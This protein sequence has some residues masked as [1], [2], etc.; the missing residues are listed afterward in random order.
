[1]EKLIRNKETILHFEKD[2]IFTPS[3]KDLIRANNIQ[4]VDK[5]NNCPERAKEETGR[6]LSS[7]EVC[8]IVKTVLDKYDE[9][10]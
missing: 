3:A 7:E 4:I 1:M 9:N 8:C 5:V 10:N 2:M 6:E